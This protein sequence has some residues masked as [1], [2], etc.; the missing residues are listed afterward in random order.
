MIAFIFQIDKE[1]TETILFMNE[2]EIKIILLFYFEESNCH[3]TLFRGMLVVLYISC[4]SCIEV[5]WR[6]KLPLRQSFHL[7]RSDQFRGT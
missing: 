4:F 6:L 5:E 7:A 1:Y 3:V 2:S